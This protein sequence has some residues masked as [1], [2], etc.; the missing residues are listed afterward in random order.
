MK[1]KL[2]LASAALL[3][4]SLTA[5]AQNATQTEL[6]NYLLSQSSLETKDALTKTPYKADQLPQV[7]VNDAGEAFELRKRDVDVKATAGPDMFATDA[8]TIFPGAVV[9]ADTDLADG[10]PTL[11]G[12]PAGTADIFVEFNTGVSVPS[13]QITLTNKE[14]SNYIYRVLRDANN[15]Y[16]PPVNL[17]AQT[18]YCSSTSEV[19][20]AIGCD[21]KYL[22]NK[23]KVDTKTTKNETKII[24]VQDF[25][26]KYYT[27]SVTPHSTKE[28]YKYFGNV[29]KSEFINRVGNRKIAVINSVTYGR[30]AYAFQ[31]YSTSDMTFTGTESAKVSAGAVTVNASSAQNIAK[32]STTDDNFVFILGGSVKPAQKV[33]KGTPIR[34]AFTESEE[35]LKIGPSNQG[36]PIAF[37]A[38]F[39]ASGRQATA[40]ATGKTTE[41]SYVKMPK[42]VD[43]EVKNNANVAGECV[44]FKDMYNVAVVRFDSAKQEY[45]IDKVYK[46]SGEYGDKRYVGYNE[47]KYSSKGTV[48]RRHAPEEGDMKKLGVSMDQAYI[49]GP[50]FYT[51]RSRTA[52][53]QD[54]SESDQ[55]YLDVTSCNGKATINIEGSA[56]A[57]SKR[58]PYVHSSSNP[59][60]IH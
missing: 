9:F 28:L 42:R 31:S 11:V 4:L 17:N 1:T 52:A 30:R 5:T 26:Q 46:G 27:V 25:T 50:V 10:R 23:V 34:E 37:T 36:V 19:A 7:V 51:V 14:V 24:S 21:A 32:R 3:A 15:L 43:F 2:L 55:G 20:Y 53:G 12:L 22:A 56:L 48:S 18:K 16:A 45:V 54:W 44:K 35:D 49:Y 47:I 8:T 58:K 57:G 40:K 39:L 60:P 41:V 13:E 6:N 29:S 59:K 33:L 38:R